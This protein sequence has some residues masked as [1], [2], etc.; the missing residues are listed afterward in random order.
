MFRKLRTEFWSVLNFQR[1]PFVCRNKIQN[2]CLCVILFMLAHIICLRQ[3][4]SRCRRRH[5]QL[6]GGALPT[7]AFK[8]LSDLGVAHTTL[9]NLLIFTSSTLGRP[10][11]LLVT[12]DLLIFDHHVLRLDFFGARS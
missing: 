7:T 9:R 11:I 3:D 12:V 4:G 8:E 2:L 6:N 1:I 10:L 5:Q